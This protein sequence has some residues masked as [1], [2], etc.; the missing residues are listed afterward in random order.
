MAS[1]FSYKLTVSLYFASLAIYGRNVYTQ[2]IQLPLSIGFNFTTIYGTRGTLLASNV[3]VILEG[4]TQNFTT[5]DSAA[6]LFNTVNSF[7]RIVPLRRGI[8]EDDPDAFEYSELSSSINFT[9]DPCTNFYRFVC[10]DWYNAGVTDPIMPVYSQPIIHNLK[11]QEQIYYLLQN[12]S[13]FQTVAPHNEKIFSLYDACVDTNGR[14]LAGS[15][16]LFDDLIGSKLNASS[17]FTPNEIAEWMVRVQPYGLFHEIGIEPDV[18]NS[19]RNILMIQP[20][21]LFLQDNAYYIDTAQYGVYSVSL[22]NYLINVIQIL[23]Q[24]DYPTGRFFPR[25]P[26]DWMR[27]VQSFLRVETQMALIINSTTKDF[28][29]PMSDNIRTTVGEFERSISPSIN[30]TRYISS[31]L[32]DEVKQRF[33]GGIPTVTLQINKM[34]IVRAYDQLLRALPAQVLSDYMDWKIILNEL[35]WLDE[36]FRFVSLQHTSIMSGVSEDVPMTSVCQNIVADVFQPLIERIYIKQ[37]YDEKTA[38]PQI[39]EMFQSLKSAF[40]EMINNNTWMDPGTKTEALN[41]LTQMGA[42]FGYMP[43]VFNDSKL[44]PLFSRM[45][46]SRGMSF[47]QMMKSISTWKTQSI[48]YHLFEPNEAQFVSFETNA[49]YDPTKNKMLIPAGILQDTFFNSSWPVQMNYGTIGSVIGHEIT[50]ALDNIGR[51]FDAQG[52]LRDWWNTQTSA[53]FVSRSQCLVDQYSA[54]EIP[55]AEGLHVNGQM[56]LGENI[57]D[58]GGMKAA[59]SALQKFLRTESQTAGQ[60]TNSTRS[61]KKVAGLEEI[62]PQQ[63]FFISHAFSLACQKITPQAQL[64]QALTDEHTPSEPRLNLVVSNMPEFSEAFKCPPGSPM[65]PVNK[66]SVW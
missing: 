34:R 40:Y 55:D 52:N 61:S 31:I 45:N 65:N 5:S 48:M 57:A 46:I 47:P 50:H 49:F 2:S 41:K 56:T 26:T 10:Q 66:C 15:A 21:G 43:T 22:Y 28:N 3:T 42:E 32:P 63:M 13:I 14:N 37:F 11:I 17:D 25:D 19:S 64:M 7:D 18:T 36:R 53:N 58:N 30:W 20:S 9:L 44:N 23:V 60:Q 62:T 8:N 27:R 39:T 29:N 59:F 35:P 12:R 38:A 6:S 33:V 1:C 51:M 54:V 16:L 24:D 4:I